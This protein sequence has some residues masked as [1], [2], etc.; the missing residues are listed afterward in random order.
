MQCFTLS[1]MF[2]I[3]EYDWVKINHANMQTHTYSWWIIRAQT[4]LHDRCVCFLS[5]TCKTKINP[6]Y[7]R[8]EGLQQIRSDM[9]LSTR[10]QYTTK[11]K[12]GFFFG[13]RTKEIQFGGWWWTN[14]FVTWRWA[15]GGEGEIRQNWGRGWKSGTG[16]WQ[17]GIKSKKISNDMRENVS[18]LVYDG[19]TST[20]GVDEISALTGHIVTFV[21]HSS[22]LCNRYNSRQLVPKIYWLPLTTLLAQNLL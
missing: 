11:H 21:T 13:G 4:F 16:W 17:C 22:T 9:R 8:N 10:E 1:V 6:Q 7:H 15:V 2:Q 3:M 12:H 19:I 5:N 20:N 14:I 18:N